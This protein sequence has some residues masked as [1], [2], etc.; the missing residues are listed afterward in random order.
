MKTDVMIGNTC[1]EADVT[2]APKRKPVE[3]YRYGLV[4]I[5]KP[6]GARKG[7]V[8]THVPTG[9][10][11]LWRRLKAEAVAARKRLEGGDLG[12]ELALLHK[13]VDNSADAS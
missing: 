1:V 11:L 5:H 7:Y 9:K 2:T 6:L 12:T 8:L 3:G 10:I 4:A 13:S